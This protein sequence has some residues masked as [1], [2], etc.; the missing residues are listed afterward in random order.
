M[1]KAIRH[2]WKKSKTTQ[3]KWRDIPCSWTGRVNI[4]KIIILPKAIYRLNAISIKLPMVFFTGIEQKISHFVWKHKRPWIGKAI[5]R[6]KNRAGFR[7]YYNATVIKTLW[8]WHKNRNTHQWN[9]IESP[10]INIH[11]DR[12]IIFNKGGKNTQCRKDSLFNEWCCENWRSTY[13]LK[14]GYNPIVIMLKHT[15]SRCYF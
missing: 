7:L 2:Q 12:H 6:K 5:L 11:I 13:L 1:Q 10:N 9:K 15:A 3:N 8:Y 4:V 14:H